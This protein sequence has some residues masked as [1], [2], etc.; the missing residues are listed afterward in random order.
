MTSLRNKPTEKFKIY[1]KYL[2]NKR[3]IAL[4]LKDVNFE[5]TKYISVK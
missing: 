3:K 1:R 2:T 4:C 5:K